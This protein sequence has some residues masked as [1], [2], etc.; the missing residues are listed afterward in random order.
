MP[1]KDVYF[2]IKLNKDSIKSIESKIGGSIGKQIANMVE[3][4]LRPG[5]QRYAI[6]AENALKSKVPYDT[7]ELR[8]SFIITE[9][10]KSGLQYDVGI[11]TGL[12]VGRDKKSASASVIAKL[13]NI[14]GNGGNWKR[15]TFSRPAGK[16]S[17][18][19]AG[20]PTRDWI[21]LS[22]DQFKINRGKILG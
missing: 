14:G 7:G 10:K 2:S 6:E 19:G 16:Y 11:A 1:I 20:Q 4:Q 3:Q 17:A 22:V 8:N 5:L 18:I 9:T 12:H 15:S 13:L 21:S